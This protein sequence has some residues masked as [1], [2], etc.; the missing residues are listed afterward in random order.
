MDEY[1]PADL[2]LS[3]SQSILTVKRQHTYNPTALKQ[4]KFN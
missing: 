2:F 4:K 3:F 1:K